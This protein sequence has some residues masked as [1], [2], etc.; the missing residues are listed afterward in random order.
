MR[1]YFASLILAG[2][3][4][5]MQSC[6]TEQ[7]TSLNYNQVVISAEGPL[8]EGSNTLQGQIESKLSERI[9]DLQIKTENI[10]SVKLKSITLSVNDTANFDL[11]TSI[12]IQFA[13]DKSDMVK[14]ALINP[15]PAGSKT[16][17]LTVANEQENLLDIL[18]QEHFTVVADAIF[19]KDSD[20]NFNMNGDF[21]FELTYKK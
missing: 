15:V 20:A 2:L 21:E 5:L 1:N 13:S 16:L 12:T 14:V 11:L 7:K 19:A 17:K 6:G 3:V 10:S 8:F 18:K 9:K 4:T